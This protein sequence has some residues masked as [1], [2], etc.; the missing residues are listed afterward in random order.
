[1]L[2]IHDHIH[3]IG[4]DVPAKIF[5]G[6]GCVY[7]FRLGNKVI[8]SLI[9]FRCNNKWR[10]VLTTT[11]FQGQSTQFGKGVNRRL[12]AVTPYPTVFYTT[13][14]YM[15]LVINGAIIQMRHPRV[16]AMGNRKPFLFI[17]QSPDKYH[18]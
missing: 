7:H 4:Q 3:A 15:R 13:K 14:R 17:Y 16:Q 12:A 18:T 11:A 2:Q 5:A 10:W 9:I 6:I 1:V 8:S